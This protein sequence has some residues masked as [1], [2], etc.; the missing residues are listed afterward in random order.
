MDGK[1]AF[2]RFEKTG[3]GLLPL[4]CL[5]GLAILATILVVDIAA[6]IPNDNRAITSKI[7]DAGYAFGKTFGY[8]ERYEAIP[9]EADY[10]RIM[11][12]GRK[13]VDVAFPSPAYTYVGAYQAADL[14]NSGFHVYLDA[15]RR[16]V[17]EVINPKGGETGRPGRQIVCFTSITVDDQLIITC[18]TKIPNFETPWVRW[19]VVPAEGALSEVADKLAEIHQERVASQSLRGVEPEDFIKLSQQQ[20]ARTAAWLID[21]APL[22]ASKLME[23]LGIDTSTSDNKQAAALLL[24]GFCKGASEGYDRVAIESYQ[25]QMRDAGEEPLE[26]EALF[27]LH[28]MTNELSLCE[29]FPRSISK[30][31]M[32]YRLENEWVRRTANAG[33]ADR[34]Q[35]ENLLVEFTKDEPLVQLGT[36]VKPF[37]AK[38]FQRSDKRNNLDSA[39]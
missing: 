5:S 26:A 6:S 13:E 24:M 18:N 33:K 12:V 3:A 19:E 17:I 35:I 20:S 34:E 1:T 21:Q 9:P 23:C 7:I 11:D 4:I 30:D 15:S 29:R 27:V 32:F 10:F 8:G 38:I 25:Q 16:S 22:P 14:P 39:R 2:E 36:I 37:N 31:A 28:A